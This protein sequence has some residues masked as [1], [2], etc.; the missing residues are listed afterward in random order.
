MTGPWPLDRF[1]GL[2]AGRPLVIVR[3]DVT[4]WIDHASTSRVAAPTMRRAADDRD[5]RVA[6]L[7]ARLILA[8]LLAARGWFAGCALALEDAPHLLD[9]R[10]VDL[11]RDRDGGIFEAMLYGRQRQV[12]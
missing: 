2:G 10:A 9:R 7:I 8:A 6:A 4:R 11:T 1:F 3:S 5:R 12:G